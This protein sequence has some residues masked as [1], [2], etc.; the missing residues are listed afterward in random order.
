MSSTLPGP[1]AMCSRAGV[2]SGPSSHPA[3]LARSS[4]HRPAGAASIFRGEDPVGGRDRELVR[5][6]RIFDQPLGAR[7]SSIRQRGRA[8]KEQGQYYGTHG[9]QIGWAAPPE[10]VRVCGTGVG[11][12]NPK[13]SK[14][15][16]RY[17]L[18]QTP[19]AAVSLPPMTSLR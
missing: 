17:M 5:F 10:Q 11:T 1:A 4:Q 15:F 13:R 8:R 19:K 18:F 7:K 12:V 3:V 6:V 2:S 14:N 9:S 16:C